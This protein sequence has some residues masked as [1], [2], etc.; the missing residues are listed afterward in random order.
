MAVQQSPNDPSFRDTRGR[1]FMKMG[2]WK[3]ALA[4]LEAA[5]AAKPDDVDLHKE[6]AEVYDHLGDADMAARAPPPGGKEA[7]RQ[8]RLADPGP[9]TVDAVLRAP[10]TKESRCPRSSWNHPSLQAVRRPGA[11]SRG[12]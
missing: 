6:L 5:L 10:L 1:V 12:G 9:V 8:G 3:D 2:R 11:P 7:E 4:D